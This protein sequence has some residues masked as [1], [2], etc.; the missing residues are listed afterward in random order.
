MVKGTGRPGGRPV[1]VQRKQASAPLQSQARVDIPETPDTLGEAGAAM[2]AWLWKECA[3]LEDSDHFA[4][5][6]L[7]ELV[8][9]KAWLMAQLD[10]ATG[11]TTYYRMPNGVLA[12]H[13][14]WTQR[15][16]VERN[17]VSS[18]AALGLT[19]T[20]RL[21][22]QTQEDAADELKRLFANRSVPRERG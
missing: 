15:K 1:S 20:D 9:E 8:D 10:L 19:P 13:P 3:W 17:I 5:L 7:C 12:Q 2:W 11:G 21:R 16:E 18:M 14:L 4:V 6:S 22:L